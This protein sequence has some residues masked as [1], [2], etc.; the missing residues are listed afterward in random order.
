M[1][2]AVLEDDRAQA[3]FVSQILTDAGHV[4]HAFRTGR[5]LIKE[6]KRETFDLLVLDWMVPDQSGEEVLR[7][8][9]QS[10]TEHVPVLFMTNR[11]ADTDIA[12]ILNAGADDYVVKPVA[13]V[14][15]RARVKSLL[16][17]V[18]PQTPPSSTEV[19]GNVEF[20]LKLKEVAVSGTLVPL[21][22]KE[23]DLALLL[24]QHMSRP[25]SRAY[26]MDVIWKQSVDITS[27]TVDTHVSALRAKLKLRPA[28][29]YRLMPIYGYGYRLEKVE[30]NET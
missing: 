14:V 8:V 27:R 22:H 7:W 16:R 6:L 26:I 25:L 20:N 24:F 2:I 30:K 23:F 5:A 19:F 17:R 29:G 28:N 18:Y 21:M 13:A 3:E 12:S 4:C 1:R 9:R 11:G 10:L 15:L